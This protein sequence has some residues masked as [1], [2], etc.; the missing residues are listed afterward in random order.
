MAEA[1]SG[2]SIAKEAATGLGAVLQRI[3]DFFDIFDLSFIISGAVTGTALCYLAWRAQT[4]LPPLPQGWSAAVALV[5]ASYVLGM[6]CFAI[7]RW[8]RAPWRSKIVEGG[9][10]DRLLTILEAHGLSNTKPISTYLNRAGVR[11]EMRLYVRL[12]AE[13]RQCPDLAPSFYL[14]RRYWVMAATYDGMFVALLVWVI[15]ILAGMLGVGA[16]PSPNATLGAFI[17]VVLLLSAVACSREAGRYV[18]YQME[19]LVA[20]IAAKRAAE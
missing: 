13:V 19:E 10:H 7:G 16:T 9:K 14:L 4:P 20:S 3:A 17:V 11:G 12:W 18:E 6:L 5:V 1:E 2:G 15:V 8:F